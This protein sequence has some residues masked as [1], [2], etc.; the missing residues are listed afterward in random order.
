VEEILGPTLG[1]PLFQEQVMELVIHAG[2]E[3]HEADQ[4]RRSMAAWKRGGDMEPHR[5]RIRELMED[6]GYSSAFI[7]QIFEQIKGFGSYGF[8]QS[9]AASFAKL[10]Y[11]SS[12][13]K[14]HEPAAF[15]CGLLNA[16]P[17]GF[18]SA[19]QIVQDACRGSPERATVMVL[20]VDVMHSDWDNTLVGGR[21]WR[22]DDEPGEQPAIRLGL[23]Q[24]AGLSE[25]MA[26]AL[27]RARVQRSFVTVADLCLRA[28]LD[29]KARTV[30]AEAGALQTLAGHR[31]AARWAVAGIERSRPLLPGS[32]IEIDIALPAPR[33][34][35]DILADYRSIGLTLRQH[36]MALLRPQMRQRRI[37][38]LEEL[39]DRHHGAGVHVAG[40]VTQ[41]QRPGTA[42]GTVFVTLEDECGM[43]NV[44]VWSHLAVRRRRALLES[45]L[46]AVRGRW[47]RVDG[48]EHLIAGDLHDLSELL[49]E[50]D[51][52]S[53]D[54]R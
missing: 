1:I 11:A 14:R 29:E 9:H 17:M 32:P 2:Y 34:G 23:R 51:V 13:L 52:A 16:Q 33:Q 44:I 31:N 37:L 53:R 27:V 38:G 5:V 36:P 43:I 30:L 41:R 22:S 12:W 6:K 48:V 46:L 54:F 7:D 18:Y 20:P 25:T 4:L 26:D 40:L 24:L 10:V 42:K 39:R 28:G 15:A 3:P 35:E 45:R 50:L 47:E 19:S 49:G 21:P 8:P